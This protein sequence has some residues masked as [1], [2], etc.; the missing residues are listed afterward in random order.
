VAKLIIASERM[1]RFPGWVPAKHHSDSG[2]WPHSSLAGSGWD[3]FSDFHLRRLAIHCP[4]DE[5]VSRNNYDDFQF[6]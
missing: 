1:N 6:L 3:W 2:C 5:R 4:S